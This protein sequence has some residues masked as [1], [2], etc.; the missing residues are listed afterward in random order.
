MFPCV[1]LLLRHKLLTQYH[2]Y[3]DTDG[4][5]V[6]HQNVTH[7]AMPLLC[8]E[9][10]S[11]LWHKGNKKYYRLCSS[12][13]LIA[14]VLG[15]T[16]PR[17]SNLCMIRPALNGCPVAEEM[18]NISD[19]YLHFEVCFK[20]P[21]FFFCIL[22]NLIENLVLQSGSISRDSLIGAYVKVIMNKSIT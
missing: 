3:L 11:I 9:W 2:N 15:C 19:V 4:F 20:I 7:Y 18:P 8:W 6:T 12:S 1:K 22:R 5:L 10:T 14:Y 21:L 16:V 13:Y 17:I